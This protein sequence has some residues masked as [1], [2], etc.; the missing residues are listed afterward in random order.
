MLRQIRRIYPEIIRMV[1]SD[2]SEVRH[3]LKA[4]NEGVVYRFISKPW[5]ADDLRSQLRDAFAQ[6]QL[7]QDNQRLRE[8]L[9]LQ[10]H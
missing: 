9:M 4:I 2:F 6:R 10:Q 8:Q 7:V 5:D 3:V 1:L